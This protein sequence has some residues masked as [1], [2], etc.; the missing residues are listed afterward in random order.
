MDKL[1]NEEIEFY[2]HEWQGILHGGDNIDPNK[3]EETFGEIVLNLPG[4]GTRVTSIS[5]KV[6]ALVASGVRI[7]HVVGVSSGMATTFRTF[8]NPLLSLEAMLHYGK[9]VN[10]NKSNISLKSLIK[11]KVFP[12]EKILRETLE[13]WDLKKSDLGK[14]ETELHILLASKKGRNFL[15]TYFLSLGAFLANRYVSKKKK[16]KLSNLLT[17]SMYSIKSK[18]FCTSILNQ[19][20]L[21]H[22]L[23]SSKDF[24]EEEEVVDVLLKACTTP[25]FTKAYNEDRKEYYLDSSAVLGNPFSEIVDKGMAPDTV[26]TMLPDQAWR[27]TSGYLGTSGYSKCNDLGSDIVHYSNPI[28][29]NLPKNHIVWGLHRSKLKPWDFTDA[30]TFLEE[31]SSGLKSAKTL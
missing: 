5:A 8:V 31:Y 25:P 19:L 17:E 23:V 1:T 11:G 28:H 21:K 3:V 24:S 26:I 12:H 30:E 2:L 7:S 29:K 14:I 20:G 6:Y 22:R 10:E 15:Y 18:P 27:Y 9:L 4:G 13:K 16:G